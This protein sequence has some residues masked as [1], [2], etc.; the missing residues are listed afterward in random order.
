MEALDLIAGIEQKFH[1]RP[2]T[3]VAMIQ[4]PRLTSACCGDNDFPRTALA[5]IVSDALTSASAA[6]VATSSNSRRH[7]YAGHE[8]TAVTIGGVQTYGMQQRRSMLDRDAYEVKRP[9]DRS[10]ATGG[11]F[12]WAHTGPGPPAG[13]DMLVTASEQPVVRPRRFTMLV[14]IPENYILGRR[15]VVKEISGEDVKRGE[16]IG[17]KDDGWRHQR[18]DDGRGVVEARNIRNPERRV[19]H[20]KLAEKGRRVRMKSESL[21]A[22][23]EQGGEVMDIP[24]A[25]LGEVASTSVDPSHPPSAAVDGV[26]ASFWLSTG[27][28]PQT[29]TIRLQRP[30]A[31]YEV[32]VACGGVHA[33]RVQLGHINSTSIGTARNILN[34]R[35]SGT[36]SGLSSIAA[37][38]GGGG[39]RDARP[40][41]GDQRKE[42]TSLELIRE[43]R[44]Y[45]KP[46]GREHRMHDRTIGR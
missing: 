7:S 27:L 31:V 8:T 17:S 18:I 4:S 42:C 36:D 35:G 19:K 5:K 33:A 10:R 30:V 13:G 26:L 22:L 40:S 29:L 20:I 44:R 15:V 24:Q 46:D 23:P 34:R 41:Q 32:M 16:G 39:D 43:Q 28:F 3:T 6:V 14:S 25:L 9:T 45:D 21:L 2:R 37:G 12:S 1:Q 38:C 11:P